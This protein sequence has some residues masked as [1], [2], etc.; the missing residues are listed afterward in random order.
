M[1]NAL[2][3]FEVLLSFAGPERVYARAI[4][5]VATANGVKVFLDEEFQ[6]EIWGQNLVEYLDRAYRER[7]SYVL[8]LMSTAYVDRAFTRVE[9]RAAFDRMITEA[10]EYILPV[11]V[12]DSWIDG[13]PKSTASL[14]LRVHGVLGVCEVLVR[15]I[16]GVTQ[17]LVVPPHVFIP[18]VPL[19]RLPAA[20]LSTYLLEL[21][22]R[23]QVTVFG[24]LIYDEQNVALRKLLRD[25]DYWDALDQASGPNVEVFAVRDT[26]EVEFEVDP[27]SS[28]NVEVFTATS[29]SRSLSRGH[30][31]SGL[32]ARYFGKEG[33]RL[34]YP[35]FAL[36]LVEGGTV[37]YCRLIPLTSTS[38]ERTFERLTDLLTVIA[39][40]IEE[41]GGPTVS[42]ETIWNHLRKTLLAS[43][44]TLYIHRPPADATEAIR[45]LSAFVED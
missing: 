6:H 10:R 13:L 8:I 18:R 40:G 45:Q 9:R 15:K 37:K 21:C 7:G 36:F 4:Y 30:F 22:A 27:D 31:F 43:K 23:P 26:E 25:S 2:E 3:E 14:D 16:R 44:Y 42:A 32:V 12:D 11:K 29:L 19:G 20:Q 1:V 38:I 28:R 33:T 5:E 41:A 24:V 35:S 17:K 39:S 34:V